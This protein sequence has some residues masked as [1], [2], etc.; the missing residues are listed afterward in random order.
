MPSGRALGGALHVRVLVL[1]TTLCSACSFMYDLEKQ[2]CTS[3]ADCVALGSNAGVCS[4]GLCQPRSDTSGLAAA[5]DGGQPDSASN[6]DGASAQDS[7]SIRDGAST[8]DVGVSQQDSGPAPVPCEGG[9]CPE[10]SVNADC[11]RRGI[12]GGVCADST[13]WPPTAQPQCS[14]DQAC[15][16]LGAEYKGG[17]CLA[18]QC[19]PNPRWR[20][21][22]PPAADGSANK[23]LSVLVRDALSLSPLTGV[24]AVLCQ[25]L[26]LQC[27]TPVLDATT[28]AEGTLQITVP[29]NF[30]GYLKVESARFLPAMYFL[31]AA[32]P[33]DGVLQP[34]PLLASGIIA[35]ALA[36]ALGAELDPSR[37]HMMLI[38][39]DCMGMAVSGATFSSPQKDASTVQFYVRDL[40]PAT[41]ATETSEVGQGGYLN[42]PPGPA[43]L[44]VKQVATGLRL[45][46]VSVVMR[47]GFVSV[48]YIRPDL[49]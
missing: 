25:K 46:T 24:R 5:A 44:D 41:E 29:G 43:V 1:L 4:D 13:C 14:S 21:E 38:A 15:E 8:L 22:R 3:Q 12:A 34:F 23:Q 42:F 39:E 17:R 45:T 20:C 6:Q 48:A 18:S 40:L 7:A 27:G 30:A 26:D 32:L 31:P 49:R 9:G 28:N 11:E 19:R 16:A 36:L 33:A 2:Q 35:D 37:G 47:P 10:C